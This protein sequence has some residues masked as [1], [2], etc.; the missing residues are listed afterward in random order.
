MT[1]KGNNRCFGTDA[2]FFMAP[3]GRTAMVTEPYAWPVFYWLPRG[4]G[5]DP[6]AVEV[7]EAPE[8]DPG[9]DAFEAWEER[10]RA[11]L[12]MRKMTPDDDGAEWDR[13]VRDE[14]HY[15][16]EVRAQ[17]RD[18]TE[19]TPSFAELDARHRERMAEEGRGRAPAKDLPE[20]RMSDA[21]LEAE[22]RREESERE[23]REWRRDVLKALRGPRA[24][25][26]I[27]MPFGRDR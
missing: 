7:W 19:P 12:R 24:F 17:A 4:A 14:I 8:G 3:D 5:G 10:R 6:G 27:T 20:H 15:E 9:G 18:A 22:A 16:L 1:R 2:D 11:V 21:E 13:V 25:L 26:G 23:E